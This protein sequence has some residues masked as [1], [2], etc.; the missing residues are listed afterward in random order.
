VTVAAFLLGLLVGIASRELPERLVPDEQAWPRRL[1]VA[2]F[3]VI[4]GLVV[5]WGTGLLLDVGFLLG[6]LTGTWVVPVL[7]LA[8]RSRRGP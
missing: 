4:L 1:A 6:L 2:T 3:V 5:A 8:R 7:V